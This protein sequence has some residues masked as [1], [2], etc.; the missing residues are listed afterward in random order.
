M[1][2]IIML[3][4]ALMFALCGCSSADNGGQGQE[5]NSVKTEKVTIAYQYGLAYAPVV[6][7]KEANLLNEKY[8]EITGNELEVEWV[9]LSSGAD[10][11]NG[12][13][14]GEI[15]AGFMGVAPA[16]TGV[17]KGLNYKIFTNIS[18]QEHGMMSNT[19]SITSLSDLVGSEN[20]IALVNIGSIQHIILA[21]ALAENGFD[22]HALD[23]NIVAMKHPDGMTSLESNSVSAHLTSSPYIFYE[24]DNPALIP[25]HEVAQAWGK[26][27]SFIVGVAAS[28]LYENKD[29]YQAL[30]DALNEAIDMINNDAEKAAG[31][32]HE[33][34]N[35]TIEVEVD[36]LGR[37]IY[38][39]ETNGL[40]ELLT[41]M[42]NNGFCETDISAYEDLV[43]DGV[44][45][46]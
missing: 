21:K 40:V 27:K 14:S 45:G 8:K 23:A 26:D 37:G 30:C 31:Y 2:K 28:S 46:N 12:I 32:T 41:F 19:D 43:Y 25:I 10:I 3:L 1:K 22:A 6:I 35:N 36:Y 20:Q 4:L 29:L 17:T 16:I 33:L 24:Q 38:T 44:V 39:T 9:Q 11:N 15:A 34:D 5:E 13:A 18:G 42:K 7:V